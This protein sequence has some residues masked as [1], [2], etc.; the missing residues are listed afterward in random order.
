MLI[1]FDLKTGRRVYVNP[2]EV[3]LLREVGSSY[4][5]TSIH[6]DNDHSV[7]VDEPINDV[8]SALNSGIK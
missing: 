3:R 1:H 5:K 2:D 6:F 7:T 4:E 8:A